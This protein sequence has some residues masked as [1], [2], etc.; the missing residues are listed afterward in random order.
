LEHHAPACAAI[1]AHPDAAVGNDGGLWVSE[2]RGARW[3]MVLGTARRDWRSVALSADG[4][5]LVAAADG[6]GVFT[7]RLAVAGRVMP[8]RIALEAEAG[9]V[10][11]VGIEGLTLDVR[12]AAVKINLA[13]KTFDR[14][15]DFSAGDVDVVTGTGTSRTMTIDGADHQ[16]LSVT[17]GFTIAISDYVYLDGSAGF[18]KRTD[19][20][21]LADGSTVKVDALLVGAA[22]VNAF[23]GLSGPYRTDTDDDGDIDDADTVNP[24]SVG[25][26][27]T[28]V[29]FGLGLFRAQAGQKDAAGNLLNGTRWTALTAE[30]G[31]IE[32]VGIPDVTLAARSFSVELNR[33]GNLP[34]GLVADAHVVDFSGNKA[35][36]VRTGTDTTVDLAMAGSF[37]QLLRVSGDVDVALGGV[38]SLSGGIQLEQYQRTVTLT[39]LTDE[40]QVIEV[41]TGERPGAEWYRMSIEIDGETYVTR[42]IHVTETPQSIEWAIDAALETIPGARVIVTTEV[43][44][45]RPVVRFAGTLSGTDIKPIRL[46]V[47][48]YGVEWSAVGSVS[49][50]VEGGDTQELLARMLVLGGADVSARI[51][52]G[53][54][55][56]AIGL[57]LKDLDFALA[58]ARPV[59]AGDNRSFLGLRGTAASLGVVGLDQFG[60]ALMGTNLSVNLN[61]GFGDD[62][63]GGANTNTI[64]WTA[65]PL[66]FK[67]GSGTPL[68]LD[69]TGTV[70]EIGGTMLVKVGDFLRVEGTVVVSRQSLE[71]TVGGRSEFVEGFLVGASD[72]SASVQGIAVDGL[73]LAVALLRPADAPSWD[74]RAW[75]AVRAEV[76]SI[77]VSAEA[78]GLPSDLFTL[79]ANSLLFETNLALGSRSGVDNDQV[80]DLSVTEVDGETVDRSIAVKTNL[81]T[82]STMTLDYGVDMGEFTTITLDAT[83]GI[84]DYVLA[85]GSFALSMLGGRTV[86]LSDGSRRSMRTTLIAARD[87]DVRLGVNARSEDDFMGV[88]LTGGSLGLALLED[89]RGGGTFI[90]LN[91]GANSISLEGVPG[92]TLAAGGLALSLNLGPTTGV[93]AGLTADFKKG[94]ID[95]DGNTGTD[96][97][98]RGET[99]DTIDT[100]VRT[101][102]AAGSVTLEIRSPDAEADAPPTLSAGANLSLEVVPGGALLIGASG[103]E[104]TVSLAGQ[105]AGIIDGRLGLVVPLP[106]PALSASPGGSPAD[107]GI[108][109]INDN[110]P[111]TK[112][113]NYAGPGTGFTTAL[114]EAKALNSL[115]LTSRTN[116]DIWQW[117]PK[118]WEVW[119]SNNSVDWGDTSWTKLGAGNTLLGDA[120]GSQSVVSFANDTPYRFY[121]VVFP[122][123]KGI[124]QGKAYMHLA[125]AL[126]FAA[127]AGT[128]NGSPGSSPNNE[129]VGNVIDGN[130]ATKYLNTTGPGS[131]FTFTLPT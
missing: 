129:L 24:D 3:R 74:D 83:L 23:A 46:V 79:D 98:M 22:D 60:L 30:A 87:V 43:D 124:S 15:V 77:A 116:D 33:V 126:L 56:E 119:G 57:E 6:E 21:T 27:M 103:I 29:D 76:D 32:L 44:G 71:V 26:S 53:S 1:L 102:K 7:T 45:D 120:R 125:E 58:Y 108:A 130:P 12:D 25:V 48:S 88:A 99:V 14:V 109:G 72:V 64:D 8:T 55:D 121:K 85:S 115:L 111:A 37:G 5:E 40:Q 75:L 51:A 127:P 73:N 80:L 11:V 2:D 105:T 38:L 35:Y 118:T 50:L 31:A 47:P 66:T 110:N 101:L 61:L 97:R 62:P 4:A 68:T 36:A 113:L 49:T 18:E 54:G 93:L 42:D 82:D 10:A 90:G 19:T 122:T 70:F 67:P 20:L 94:D 128:V 96:I 39:D 114:P 86:T 81:A 104:A 65:T 131:G 84:S 89:T 107:E 41:M 63:Q 117:D 91:A 95:G 13:D 28:D 52:T 16:M 9:R 106:A 17:A 34:A 112:Y 78:L 59:D 100:R 92:V 123:T 69:F